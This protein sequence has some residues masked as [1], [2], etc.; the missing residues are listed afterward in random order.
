VVTPAEEPLILEE[1]LAEV[2]PDNL[3]DEV[4]TGPIVGDET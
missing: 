4:D 2:T 3:H 1:Q